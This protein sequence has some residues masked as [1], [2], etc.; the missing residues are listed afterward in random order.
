M[1][2]PVVADSRSLRLMIDTGAQDTLWLGEEG[3]PGDQVV[4][5]TD[6][7]GAEI[8]LYY[9]DVDLEMAGEDAVTVPCF[10]APSFPYFEQ[11]VAALGGNLH[12]LLGLSSLRGRRFVIDGEAH[13]ILLETGEP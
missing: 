11:T 13:A 7:T 3:E 4:T 1:L 6:A 2:A 9:G 12:G 10:R 8:D 5:T